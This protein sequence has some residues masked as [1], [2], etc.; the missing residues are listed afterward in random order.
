MCGEVDMGVVGNDVLASPFGIVLNDPMAV[1]VAGSAG[2][3]IKLE[4]NVDAIKLAR[5][6]VV[7]F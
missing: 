3:S 6:D 7:A 2:V 4:E 5:V 1:D